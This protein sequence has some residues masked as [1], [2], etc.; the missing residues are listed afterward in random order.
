MKR[1]TLLLVAFVAM[2]SAMF[3]AALEQAHKA[4]FKY[5]GTAGMVMQ[6]NLYSQFT[7]DAALLLKAAGLVAASADGTLILDVGNGLL[8]CCLVL[9]V[10]ALEVDSNDEGYTVILEGSNSATFAVAADI[11]PLAT[12]TIG[13]HLST[14]QALL[15]QGADDTVGRYVVCVRNERNGNTY[16]Y[17]RTRTQVVG[18]IATGINYMA[19]LAKD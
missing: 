10:T 17:L 19:W 11:F 1:I 9:D 14:P 7:Y 3:D 4:L 6:L 5:M 16:R 2:I 12:I 8:D 15:Q 18:T 13:D